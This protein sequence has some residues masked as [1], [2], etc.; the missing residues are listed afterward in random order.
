LLLEQ[1]QNVGPDD[2]VA[3]DRRFFRYD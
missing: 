3:R 2:P 1:Q